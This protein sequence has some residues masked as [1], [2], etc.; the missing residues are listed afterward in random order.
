M[1][2]I[3]GSA[4]PEAGAFGQKLKG[5][6]VDPTDGD[7]LVEARGSAGNEVSDEVI[8]FTESGEYQARSVELKHRSVWQ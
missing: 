6:A 3:T 4:V 8:E 1:R 5:V 2:A 7:I